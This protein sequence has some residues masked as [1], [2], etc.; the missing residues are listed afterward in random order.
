MH[1]HRFRVFPLTVPEIAR[2]ALW[3]TRNLDGVETTKHKISHDKVV[4]SLDNGGLALI[5][6][7]QAA[8][9]SIVSSMAG[10]YRHAWENQTSILNVLDNPLRD[11]LDNQLFVLNGRNVLHTFKNL[12]RIFPSTQE[13]NSVTSLLPDIFSKIR[14][15]RTSTSLN[16]YFSSHSRPQ[17]K[18][19]QHKIEK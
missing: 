17:S 9:T 13:K 7:R 11:G 10:F 3:T 5:H 6:P 14:T 4:K 8:I 18:N 12:K 2:K 1:N 19:I 15:R 16:A